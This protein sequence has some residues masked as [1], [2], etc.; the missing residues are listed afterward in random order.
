MT[1]HCIECGSEKCSHGN[2][3]ECYPCHHCSGG[4]RNNKYY[5]EEDTNLHPYDRDADRELDL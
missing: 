1:T 2:C 4:D 3:P 5:G